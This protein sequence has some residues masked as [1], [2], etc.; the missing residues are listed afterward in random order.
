MM[1]FRTL[2]FS[3]VLMVLIVMLIRINDD[4][5]DHDYHDDRDDN[6][7]NSD[8]LT[9]ARSRDGRAHQGQ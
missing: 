6:F 5:D 8:L 2:I 3:P 7:Q 1:I 4:F 9:C